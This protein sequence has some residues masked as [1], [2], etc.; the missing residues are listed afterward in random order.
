[1]AQ[2]TQDFWPETKNRGTLF[3]FAAGGFAGRICLAGGE[4]LGKVLSGRT[5]GPWGTDW[6]WLDGGAFT[7][8]TGQ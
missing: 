6:G 4:G 3:P 1:M 2:P 7:V 8:A 5:M